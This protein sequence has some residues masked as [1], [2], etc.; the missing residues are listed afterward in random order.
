VTAPNPEVAALLSWSAE[1]EA[2]MINDPALVD[3]TLAPDERVAVRAAPVT[4]V[5]LRGE[6]AGPVVTGVGDTGTMLAT[7]RRVLLMV[8]GGQNV[9]WSWAGDVGEV[10]P[11]RN[12][13][14]V[15]WSPSPARYATGARLEG[16]ALP[17]FARGE[18]PLPPPDAALRALWTKVEV[19]WRAS[20]PGGVVAWQ[21]QFRR[22]YAP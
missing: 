10:T 22:R 19:A 3:G 16:L 7:D 5:T 6:Q 17:K 14:G 21:D 2:G 15:M 8:D 9:G 13:L 4:A 11:L 1:F 18:Q 20:Q 12:F